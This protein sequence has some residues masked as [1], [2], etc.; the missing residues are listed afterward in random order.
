VGLKS[1]TLG[2]KVYVVQTRIEGRRRRIVIVR[3]GEIKL[4]EA[5]RRARALLALTGCRRSEVLDLCWLNVCAD[6][7][8]LEESKISP[9]AV[10][11]GEVPRVQIEAMPGERRPDALLFAG[12]A[13]GHGAYSFATCWRVVGEDA[14]L[15][16]LR[17]HRLL[18]TRQPAKPR[19]PAR[20]YPLSATCPGTGGTEPPPVMLNSA[21]GTWLG[22]RRK[23][24][25]W[26]S[27]R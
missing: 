1:S 13:E 20:T 4:A 9:R 10:P 12:Y 21:T 17:L 19:C 26:S 24:E 27:A 16:S 18:H 3:Y 11:L 14:K 2:W 23:L 22:R 5:R 15:G 7:L 6:A 8:N 25:Y